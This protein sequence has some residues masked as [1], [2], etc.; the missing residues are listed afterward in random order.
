VKREW[1]VGFLLDN[2][3]QR[4]VLI[5]KARPEW[6]AGRLNGVG[7]KL[8][9]GETLGDA[10]EREFWEET[11]VAVN[12]WRPFASLAWEEGVVYFFRAFAP[13]ELLVDCRTVTDEAIE[14]HHVHQLLNPA[15]PCG[16][17]TPNLRW[18]VP[19]AAHRH[20]TYDVIDVVETGTTMRKPGRLDV[21]A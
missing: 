12:W 10:M 15:M 17:I 1:V 5:R 20:D 11:G 8:E 9:P 21:I 6:Q 16:E 4:V 13:A 19:L 3:A 2:A 7:G 18:L 14:L